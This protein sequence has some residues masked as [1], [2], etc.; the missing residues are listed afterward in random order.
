MSILLALALVGC[1]TTGRHVRWY[2]G[3]PLST[4]E[5]AVLRVQRGGSVNLAVD[6][7]N[8]ERLDKG[9]KVVANTTTRIELRPGKY[10]LMVQYLDTG[11]A[12]SV[13]DAR[14]DLTAEAGK[15][16]ELHGAH[17]E[18]SFGDEWKLAIV[19]GRFAWTI[20]IVDAATGRTV[21]GTPRETPL[22]WY[23]K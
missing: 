21:A 14:I 15:I 16:Y 8:G 22:H 10:D 4:N 1:S 9:K 20:W 2:E 6:Q 12:R 17:G 3:Q 5:I 11:G 23:E 19:G 7:I 13:G 18:R